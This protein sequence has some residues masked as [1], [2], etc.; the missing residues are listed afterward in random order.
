MLGLDGA[1]LSIGW[2]ARE[3]SNAE[4]VDWLRHLTPSD[5]SGDINAPRQ[6][7]LGRCRLVA[8]PGE[9]KSACT[10]EEQFEST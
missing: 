5:A 10:H 2:R 1:D 8:T 7:A 3:A 9:S 6:L 4:E